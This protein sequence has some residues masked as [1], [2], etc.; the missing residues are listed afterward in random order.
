MIDGAGFAEVRTE[1]LVLAGLTLVFLTIA[2]MRF[3]WNED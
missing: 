3:K 1:L 2:S